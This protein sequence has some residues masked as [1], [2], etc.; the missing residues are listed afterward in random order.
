MLMNTLRAYFKHLNNRDVDTQVT[1]GSQ[2]QGRSES[3][4]KSY[5]RG[6]SAE[7]NPKPGDPAEN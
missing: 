5:A 1:A 7:S 4:G 2:V 3:Y 6:F